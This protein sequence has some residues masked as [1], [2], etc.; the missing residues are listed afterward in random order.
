MNGRAG[1]ASGKR[2]LRGLEGR[3]RGRAR[4][5]SG[6]PA[7]LL[8]SSWPAGRPTEAVAASDLRARLPSWN[9]LGEVRKQG[10]SCCRSPRWGKREGKKEGTVGERGGREKGLDMAARQQSRGKR[11]R[12]MYVQYVHAGSQLFGCR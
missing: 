10:K 8:R 9:K 11:E 12:A 1:R 3:G 7:D 2:G 6:Q 4:T 5:T